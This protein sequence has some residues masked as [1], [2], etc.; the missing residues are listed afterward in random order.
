MDETT[1]DDLTR[2]FRACLEQLPE[3]S[4]ETISTEGT[5]DLYQL[6]GELTALKNEV[7]IESRT[8]KSALEEFRAVFETLR[9]SQGQ[10]TA[11]L[12][13]SRKDRDDLSR[14]LLRP[15]L[16][17]L[18]DLYDRLSAGLTA[19]TAHRPSCLAFLCKREGLLLE[20]LRDGQQMT[21]RRLE[22]LLASQQVRPLEVIDQRFDPSC[23]HAA[24]TE[25]RPELADGVV[26][27]E[28][29][30][31]FCWNEELLRIPE[32]KINKI[33]KDRK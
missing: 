33:A 26:T 22:A 12:T 16:G 17:E 7:K 5:T 21:L 20:G 14:A 27:D 9:D 3:E 15:L 2:Q 28:L 32:V 1:K 30:K 23:M 29:R 25:S 13:R 24:A 19:A 18:L 31:G 6:F 8:V 10:L 11:E 4:L